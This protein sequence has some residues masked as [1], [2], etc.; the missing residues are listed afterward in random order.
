[1]ALLLFTVN[2][3]RDL[4]D[5]LLTAA[6]H[7]GFG[8][9][10]ACIML[11]FWRFADQP[12]RWWLIAL[13]IGIPVASLLLWEWWYPTARWRIVTTATGQV[14]FLVALFAILSRPRRREMAGIYGAL[15]WITG[16]YLP[17][18]VWSYASAV[19][20]LP[21]T[22]RI[23]AA[24]HGVTFSVGSMLFMLALAVGFLALQYSL[25]ACR[26]ADQARRDW[27]TGLLN[28]RGV[29]EI[30][31]RWGV[32]LGQ[33]PLLGV[34]AV[35]I[36]HFKSIN[37]RYGHE[38]GDSVLERLAGELQRQAGPGSVVGR[39]GGEEFLVLLPDS[40]ERTVRLRAERLRRAS[41]RFAI[42]VPDRFIRVTVSI[43]YAF[44]SRGESLEPVLRR[45][46]AALYR[47]KEQ[48]RNRVVGAEDI[49]QP[50]QPT[51]TG[52]H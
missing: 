27:L 47:A 52:V 2:V 17:L 29:V 7:L 3:E 36:D 28:R 21:T 1:M 44:G 23:P 10:S 46:D 20:L 22:A 42:E 11:G 41:A 15:R 45:A 38:V 34:M 4:F 6:N 5:S 12:V 25:L 50:A 30:V 43:G 51:S 16:A 48:G 19:E 18:L 40:D 9:S 13:I 35:D 49:D 8:L 32:E 33:R 39:M 31:D 26:H 14:I 37:D 24:Y